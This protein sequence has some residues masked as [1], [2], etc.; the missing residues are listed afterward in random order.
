MR[1]RELDARTAPDADLLAVHAIEDAY[2]RELVPDEPGRS[3][4]E[5]IAFYRFQPTTH[6]TFVWLADGGFAALFV[7]GPEAA[8]VQL[9]AQPE[10]RRRGIGTALL[11]A[12]KERA[13]ERGVRA[14]HGAHATPDGAA[15]AAAVGARDGQ[16]EVR[17]LIDLR[18]AELPEPSL[19]PNWRLLT[20]LTRVPDEHL[21]AF[22]RGRA[23]MDDA[24]GSEEI[25]FPTASAERIRAS[26]D[27]LIARER[28]MRVTVA[29]NEEGEIG[30]F[31]ELRVSRGSMLGFTDD[32][33]TVAARR[34]QGLARAVKLESLRR[35]R[36][37]HPEVTVVT[38]MNAEENAVMR[39]INESVGFR[40]AAV[41]TTATLRL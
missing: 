12:V 8:F 36:A 38:T 27:S 29:M 22:V 31:T 33:G 41:L 10:N 11:H 2:Q 16:R 37:D 40:P 26:E 19:P 5:A 9:I 28:E 24:P 1:I 3:A 13:L 17:S 35:L 7:H 34:G 4:E 15:F 39:H 21:A 25:G 20:W 32:T 6:E 14:M 23:A 30:S 18:T